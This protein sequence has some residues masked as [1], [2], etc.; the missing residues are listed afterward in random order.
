MAIKPMDEVFKLVKVIHPL[1]IRLSGGRVGGKVM[2]MPM[3]V[4]TTTGRKTG[5]PR[6]TPL[7][8]IEDGGHAY[9]VASKG[10]DDRHPAWYLNLV[11]APEVSV[12]RDGR[13]EPMVARVLDAEEREAIWPVVTRTYK[14]YASY[15]KKTDRRIPVVELVP[16]TSGGA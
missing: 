7:T 9:I 5:Q 6:D 12:R 3:I 8:V 11:D 14:G 13:T 10:G 16:A 4:L 2:G 15:E 1:V